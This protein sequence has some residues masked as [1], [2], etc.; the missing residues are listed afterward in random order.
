[1]LKWFTT[2]QVY[3]WRLMRVL[4]FFFPLAGG[5]CTFYA[6]AGG[7]QPTQRQLPLVQ[8]KQQ[9][10]PLLSIHNYTPLIS[11]NDKNKQLTLLSQCK[12]A[13]TARNIKY[14]HFLQYKIFGAHKNFK[15]WPCPLFRPKTNH[16]IHQK[17]NPCRDV[18]PLMPVLAIFFPQGT[19]IQL[20]LANPV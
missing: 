17:P 19:G 12:L 8:Y 6:N 7:K 9:A 2:Q 3:F 10:H 15:K 5:L 16:T 20:Q 1:M 14:V 18:V 11:R 13:L 4:F